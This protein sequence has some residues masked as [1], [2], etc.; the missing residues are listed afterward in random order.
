M[1][2]DARPCLVMM[3]DSITYHWPTALLGAG[4]RVVNR[5]VRRQTSREMLARFAADVLA[6]RP[7]VVAILA[8]TNDLK[9]RADDAES[10]DAKSGQ[11]APLLARLDAMA[12]AARARGIRVVLGAVP[13]VGRDLERLA[14]DPAV[15]LAANAAI[16]RLAAAHGD[17]FADYHAALADAEGFLPAAIAADGL[18]PNAEGYRLM[19]PRLLGALAACGVA[20]RA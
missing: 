9:R 20:V 2:G 5:G 1:S 7:D 11:V 6:E 8:G 18:H 3:G 19:S 10:D 13:P 4:L 16:R 12:G 15:I 14:R 17:G